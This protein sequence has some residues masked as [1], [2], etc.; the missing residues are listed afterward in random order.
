MPP[1]MSNLIHFGVL[2]LS[3]SGG[4]VLS[5]I[6]TSAN[7]LPLPFLVALQFVLNPR[8]TSA[9]APLS[10]LGIRNRMFLN[11]ST[12]EASLASRQPDSNGHALDAV[13]RARAVAGTDESL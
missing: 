5:Q 10:R 3:L 6:Q 12:G 13:R 7:I 2:L 9:K 11:R 1:T 4:L 8:P